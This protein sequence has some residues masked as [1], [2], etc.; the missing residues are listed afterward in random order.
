MKRLAYNGNRLACAAATVGVLA[1]VA[2]V[3]PALGATT[4]TVTLTAGSLGFVGSPPNVTFASTAP[5]AI[6]QA[7]TATGPIDIGDATGSSA[8]WEITATSTT[9]TSGANTLPTAATTIASAPATPTCDTNSTCAPATAAGGVTY[10]Y[11]LPAATTAPAGTKIYAATAG[12]G[13]GEETVTPTW[14]LAIPSKAVAG[15]YTSTWTFTLAS[16]P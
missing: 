8:G 13:P 9:F 12:A 16:G 4:A 7:I 14:T 1:A 2:V 15:D 3:V 11:S 5:T 6:N 10:P